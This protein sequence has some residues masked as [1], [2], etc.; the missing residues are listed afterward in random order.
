MLILKS[1]ALSGIGRFTEEQT[2]NFSELGSLVEV[3]GQNNCT[4]GSSGAGKSTIFKALSWCLGLDG[5]ST[6]ILQSRL[7]KNSVQVTAAFDLDGLPLTVERGRKLSIDYNGQITTGSSKLTEERLDQILGMPRELFSKILHKKQGEGGFFLDMGP[8]EVHKF[9]TSCLG[10]EREQAKLITLDSRLNHLTSTETSL[11]SSIESNRTGLEATLSAI[12]SLGACPELTIGPEAIEALKKAHTDASNR[13]LST[14]ASLKEDLFNLE[15]ERPTITT[16]P[17]DRS[18]LEQIEEEIGTILAQISQL[19]NVER[20]RQS[21]IKTQISELQSKIN[22]LRNAELARQNEVKAKIFSTEQ[23]IWKLTETETK[24]QASVKNDITTKDFK[25]IELAAIFSAGIKAKE[26][27]VSLAEEL[28]KVRTS[29]CPTCEQSWVNDAAKAKEATLLERLQE[30]KK[31]VFAGIEAEKEI[32]KIEDKRKALLEDLKPRIDSQ[33]QALKEELD[34]YLIDSKSKEIEEIPLLNEQINRLL[35]DSK[36]QSIPE[37]IELKMTIDFKNQELVAIRQ[38]ERN[39]QFKENAKAQAILVKFT[40]KQTEV[41]NRYEVLIGFAQT[42]ENRALSDYEAAKHE[43]RSFEE[44]KKRYDE[45]LSKLTLN[46]DCYCQGLSVKENELRAAQDE[47]ELAVESKKAI[48]SYLSCSFEDALDSIGD[49]ATRLIREIPNMATA[50][51]QFEGLKETKEGKIKEETVCLISMD[52]EIGVPVKS[53]SGGERSSV[54]LAIDLSV[55]KFIEETTGKGI[56]LFILDEPF[57]GM[58]TTCI[59]D[60]V[61]MLKSYAVDKQLFL[62]EHNPIVSQ[63]IENRLIVVRDG[64]TS[65]IVQQ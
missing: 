39:H 34:G 46:R 35:I 47:I 2:I 9:L 7:T 38:E 41:K 11:K 22:D 57:T 32:L 40:E 44:A 26:D 30:Y 14:K 28:K 42:E 65:K 4:G 20:D 5:P 24:R 60:A 54:D 45:S 29:I 16:A 6:S 17:F 53:L 43:I 36:A 50:T 62:V 51:I 1:L 37:V 12:L 18:R 56:D 59:Q 64:L 48:K 10:Q 52:G 63:S 27:A 49:R 55:I 61:E 8:S 15:I 3:S 58:D 13:Y 19:E 23:A 33:S 21:K 25:K 31:A